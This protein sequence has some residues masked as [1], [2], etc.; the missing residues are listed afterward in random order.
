MSSPTPER[1]I[2]GFVM[3]LFSMILIV[4]YLV[5]ALVPEKI[6]DSLGL[7]YW[8]EKHWAVSVPA[9]MGR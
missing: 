1:A 5:W 6:L 4:V 3:Y 8:P 7:A 9:F 2:Y